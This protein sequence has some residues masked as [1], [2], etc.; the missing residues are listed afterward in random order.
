VHSMAHKTGALFSLPHGCAN[1]IMLPYVIEFNS[2]DECTAK[3]Y[4][5]IAETLNFPGEDPYSSSQALADSLRKL[6]NQLGIPNSLKECGISEQNFTENVA[7]ICANAINDPC[8]GSNPRSINSS[9]MQELLT[10]CYY[11]TCSCK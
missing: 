9:Q 1:A 7:N 4:N 3:K 8:T 6:N 10:K 2:K 11:G 5:L